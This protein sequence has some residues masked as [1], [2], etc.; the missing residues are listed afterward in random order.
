MSGTERMTLAQYRAEMGLQPI[1]SGATSNAPPARRHKYGTAPVEE[2]TYE[3]V[4]FDSKGEM[5]RWCVLLWEHRIG[6]ITEL[7]RQVEYRLVVNEVLIAIYRPDYRYRRDGALVIED[8]KSKP[9][10]TR[11]YL[12]KRRLMKALHGIDILETVDSAGT[13]VEES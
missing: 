7:E 4:V 13:P 2:R 11:A 12:M 3:G 6:T 8:H 5:A 1:A 9:T 10:R